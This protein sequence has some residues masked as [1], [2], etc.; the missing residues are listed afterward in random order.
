MKKTTIISVFILLVSYLFAQEDGTKAT[1]TWT[2]SGSTLWRAPAAWS[3]TGVPTSSDAV[4]IDIS[5][6]CNINGSDASCNSIRI[7]DNAASSPVG[8]LN[9][10][11]DLTCTN[12]VSIE[13]GGTIIM[14][15]SSPAA[16]ITASSVIISVGGLLHVGGLNT[17]NADIECYGKIKITPIADGGTAGLTVSNNN[18]LE[19]K[20]STS[21][22]DIMLVEGSIDVTGTTYC[23]LTFQKGRWVYFS[24]PVSDGTANQLYLNHSPEV[25]LTYWTAGAAPTTAFNYV[26]SLTTPLGTY[27]GYSVWLAGSI[28]RTFTMSGNLKLEASNSY[29]YTVYDATNNSSDLDG[30]N[31]LGNPFLCHL[32]VTQMTFGS[33]VV[34]ICYIWNG[35]SYVEKDKTPSGSEEPQEIAMLQSFFVQYNSNTQG[36]T[37]TVSFNGSHTL[38]SSYDGFL[39]KAPVDNIRPENLMTVQLID[40]VGRVDKMLIWLNNDATNEFDS[41]YDGS[42]LFGDANN[43]YLYHSDDV[44]GAMYRYGVPEPE[45]SLDVSVTYKIGV[46]GEYKLRFVDVDNYVDKYSITLH[47]LYTDETYDVREMGDLVFS[48]DIGEFTDRFVVRFNNEE[49]GVDIP[50]EQNID[51]YNVGSLVYVNLDKKPHNSFSFEM[52]DISG[53]LVKQTELSDMQSSVWVDVPNGYYLVNIKGAGINF[54]EKVY[55]GN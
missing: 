37:S 1:K 41:R 13:N 52:F 38:F 6:V 40:E 49:V 24:S 51:I 3:A 26:T 18:D 5:N 43:H 36:S 30:W 8:T 34:D 46:G 39:K 33:D 50:E 27:P 45:E 22:E 7:G 35:T 29:S 17:I 54:T 14:R 20:T 53:R 11:D 31:M 47:D 15:G 48:S 42:K 10:V 55:I 12:D 21:N 19:L 16:R 44:Y 2:A 32:D 9:M 25:Y 23:D 4:I 28:N